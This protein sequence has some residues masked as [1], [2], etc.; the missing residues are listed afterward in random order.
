MPRGQGRARHAALEPAQCAG[1]AAIGG[2]HAGMVVRTA[3]I[4]AFRGQPVTVA[5]GIAVDRCAPA[6]FKA[7]AQ[8][9]ASLGIA[10]ACRTYKASKGGPVIAG[11]A[12][13]GQEHSAQSELGFNQTT[14]SGSFQP[15]DGLISGKSLAEFRRVHGRQGLG[16]P[17]RGRCYMQEVNVAHHQESLV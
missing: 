7:A 14:G 8:Q 12:V 10:A 9:I 4:A 2:Q 3:K 15:I 11:H 16:P 6:I 13:S 1:D 5:C 17:G